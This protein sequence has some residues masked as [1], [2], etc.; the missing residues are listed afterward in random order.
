MK[1]PKQLGPATISVLEPAP[2][3]PMGERP[4]PSIYLE[5]AEFASLP[6]KGR[7]TFEFVRRRVTASKEAG[8]KADATVVLALT[9]ICD[10]KAAK[11][12]GEKEKKTE[13]VLDELL[14]EAREENDES[15][16]ESEED[17]ED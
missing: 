2:S 15:E 13:D 17:E 11:E 8:A 14:E 12:K 4:A 6:E 10:V 3:Q 5:G 1:T 16:D 9:C 7:I